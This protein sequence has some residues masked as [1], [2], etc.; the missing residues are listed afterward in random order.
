MNQVRTVNF[1]ALCLICISVVS[2][3]NNAHSASPNNQS[4][5]ELKKSRVASEIEYFDVK[6]AEAEKKLAEARR[7]YSQKK[8]QLEVQ[9]EQLGAA[10]SKTALKLHNNEQQRLTVAKLSIESRQSALERLRRK[11]VNLI[12]NQKNILNAIANTNATMKVRAQ[13]SAT[14]EVSRLKKQNSALEVLTANEQRRREAAELRIEEVTR[15]AQAQRSKSLALE[16]EIA[17]LKANQGAGNKPMG[18]NKPGQ[19]RQAQANASRA[20]PSDPSLTA[21]EG[22]DPIYQGE[23][24]ERIVIRSHSI[25]EKVVMTQISEHTYQADLNVEPGRAYFDLRRKRYR[26]VFPQQPDGNGVYRFIYNLS[27]EDR[28][29]LSVQLLESASQVVGNDIEEF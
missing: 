4:A 24:G 29:S 17:L 2:L 7:E 5:L 25:E 11:Q 3:A 19:P 14:S 22:E 9:T 21:L 10:P 15:A 13:Q 20:Q 8:K 18:L 23:D 28:P 16:R 26:G 6:I 27:D 12:R 1:I